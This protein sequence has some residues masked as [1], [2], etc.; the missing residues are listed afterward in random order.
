VLPICC[1]NFLLDDWLLFDMLLVLTVFN[2]KKSFVRNRK[3][4][5]RINEKSELYK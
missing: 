4:R 1:K 5:I 3:L 2:Y